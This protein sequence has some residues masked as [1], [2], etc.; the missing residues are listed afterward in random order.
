[1]LHDVSASFPDLFSTVK[2]NLVLGPFPVKGWRE[3]EDDDVHDL[4]IVS[5]HVWKRQRLVS[6][7]AFVETFT[8]YISLVL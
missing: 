1:M 2:G 7:V 4:Q 3:I 5:F 8:V 6:N